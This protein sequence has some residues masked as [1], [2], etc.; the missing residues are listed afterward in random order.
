MQTLSVFVV[1]PSWNLVDDLVVCIDSLLGSSSQPLF[2]VVV[3]N[4]STDGT[5][6]IIQN[7]FK[8]SVK[9]IVCE[10][11]LGFARAV[12]IGIQFAVEAGAEFVLVLNNDTLV[13]SHMVFD[14]VNALE[15]YPAVGIASPLIYRFDDPDCIWRIGDRQL[16]GP[17]LIWKIAKLP[18]RQEPVSVEYV[19]GCAMMVKREVFSVVGGFAT[20]Y[21]M[22]FEDAD[23]CQ[24]VR[25]S[26]FGI[27]VVPQ[28][29]MWHKVSQSTRTLVPQ[30]VYDQFRGRVIFMN[31]HSPLALW[32][33][34]NLYIWVRL[35]IEF[36]RYLFLGDWRSA[37]AAVQGVLAGYLFLVAR[38]LSGQATDT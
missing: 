13:D 7:R 9:V 3:D 30:R 1:I 34:A 28:A 19:T 33:L 32:G 8:E 31:R 23:F 25:A 21:Q 5:C 29:K 17:P 6:G 4:A 18:S 35:M 20:D 10:Q 37:M 38:T 2:V 15:S 24:R 27:L 16:W 12:N 14:L 36:G 11:N 26:G 22:Y